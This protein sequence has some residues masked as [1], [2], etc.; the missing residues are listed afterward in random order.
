[1]KIFQNHKCNNHINNFN[2]DREDI[3]S[4]DEEPIISENS[5][6]F[7]ENSESKAQTSDYIDSYSDKY[8]FPSGNKSRDLMVLVGKAIDDWQRIYHLEKMP[9]KAILRQVVALLKKF[10]EDIIA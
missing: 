1:M 3:L 9:K 8:I 2:D 7:N 4:K 6:A 5:N 10:E